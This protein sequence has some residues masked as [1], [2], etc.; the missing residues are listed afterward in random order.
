MS[1]H[2]LE[3]GYTYP[4][5]SDDPDQ[6]DVLRNRLG[7]R[8]HTILS[9][10]EYRMTNDRWIEIQ[11]GMGPQGNFGTAHLKAI[12]KHLF[13]DIYEWAGHTRN[14]SP[15]VDGK[16]V[17]TIGILRKGKTTFLPGS[18]IEMGLTEALRPLVKPELLKNV[19]VRRFA[20]VAGKVLNELNYVHPFREGNGRAQEAF[21][22][23]LGR[24]TGHDVRFS[25]ISRPRMM[26]ASIAGIADPDC[27]AMQD[28]LEDAADPLR[29]A[30]LTESFRFLRQR[31]I[32]PLKCDIRTARS[33]ETISG[34][35][36]SISAQSCC[37]DSP[38]Q[39]MIVI[40]AYEALSCKVKAGDS[41][42]LTTA[43]RFLSSSTEKSSQNER[44]GGFS[45]LAAALAPK[46][47]DPATSSSEWFERTIRPRSDQD[48]TSTGPTQADHSVTRKRP[49]SPGDR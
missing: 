17:E 20:A 46:P 24:Q 18:R 44:E 48:S 14:E 7:I 41:V 31:G 9:Q 38:E 40:P 49:F 23:E 12:H 19:S 32:E 5:V 10:S 28:L 15:V 45:R 25:V 22:S 33:G 36:M 3:H 35:V 16:P 1:E 27:K 11:L 8:S 29:S 43:A 21:I 30:A 47:S 13:N 2:D 26:A 4:N 39:G 34:T 6:R 42:T 37:L